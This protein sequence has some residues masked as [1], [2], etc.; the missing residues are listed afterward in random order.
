MELKQLRNF[1]AVAQAEHVTRAARQLGLSQP[2]LSRTIRRLER[3]IGVPLFDRQGRQIR[4][5]PSGRVFLRQVES[6]L[7]EL[8]EGRREVVDRAGSGTGEVVLLATALRSLPELLRSFRAHHPRVGFRL[9]QAGASEMAEQLARGEC[10]LSISSVPIEGPDLRSVPLMTEEILLALPPGHRFLGRTEADL[11]EFADEPF[12][13]LRRG[14]DLRDLTDR[15]CQEAGFVPDVVCE[16]NEPGAIRNMVAAGLGVAF[17]PEVSWRMVPEPVPRGLHI[18]R[19][20]CWRTLRL[21]WRT[22]RYESVAARS[23]RQ[24]TVAYFRRFGTA[25]GR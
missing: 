20:N 7:H 12:V 3:E 4:L 9:T 8:E 15:F 17:L 1:R 5:N 13:A 24:F 23:F 22:E 10:D 16:L 19:P 14:Y 25:S 2:S 11:R 6:A 21:V 18:R